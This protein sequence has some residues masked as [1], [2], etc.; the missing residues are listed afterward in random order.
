MTTYTKKFK[1]FIEEYNPNDGDYVVGYRKLDDSEVKIPLIALDNSITSNKYIRKDIDDYANGLISLN[2]GAR[3]GDNIMST[4]YLQGLDGWFGTRR[5]DFEMNSL[6]LREFL[7]VPELRKNKITVMGNQ[8]WFTDSALVKEAVG[9]GMNQYKILFKLEDEEYASF[10][11]NDILKGIYHYENGFYTVYLQ[12]TEL[13]T[14]GITGGEIGVIVTSLNGKAPR[15]SMLLA[16]M[17]NTTD[18]DRQ[19]SI[20]A[21]GLKKYIRVLSGF[22]PA[23]PT[24]EGSYETL[25]VQLG[26]LSGIKNH[27]VFGSLEGYGLYADN[28]YLTGKLIV[29]ND[30]NQPGQELGVYRGQWSSTANYYK[31]DQVTYNGSLFT[32]KQ[33]NNIGHI[34]TGQVDDLWWELTVSKGDDGTSADSSYVFELSN[35]NHT[36]PTDWEGKNPSYGGATSTAYVFEGGKDITDVYTITATVQLPA[37]PETLQIVQNDNTV[38]ITY[39]AD[40]LDAAAILFT[41]TAKGYPTL[42]KTWSISKVKAGQEGDPAVAYWLVTDSPVIKKVITKVSG[43]DVVSYEPSPFV[44]RAFTQV[45]SGPVQQYTGFIRLTYGTQ[46]K[47]VSGA[48]YQF[49]PEA[50]VKSYTIELFQNTELTVLLDKEIVSVVSDGVDGTSPNWNLYIYY[51]GK[52]L[53]ATPTFKV[54]PKDYPV[55]GWYGYPTSDGIWWM[56]TAIVNGV[57]NVIAK[58]SIPIKVTG[59]DGNNGVDGTDGINGK[60]G[61]SLKYK[62]EFNSHPANP[63][64]GWYYYNTVDGKSYVYQDGAWYQMTVDGINGSNGTNGVS[65]FKSTVFLRSNTTP[66]TPTG[67]SYAV[68]VP[69]GWSDGAPNGTTILWT[70]SRI[71]SSTGDIPQTPTWSVPAQMTNTAS[72]EA[73][74]S[75]ITSNPGTPTTNPGNWSNTATTTSIWMATRTAANGVWSAWSV[76]KVKGE[77]GADGINGISIVW[78]GDLATPPANPEI[79]WVYR[80]T[81]N[82]RVYIWNGMAWELMVLDGSDGIDGT[83]G[84]TYYTWLQYSDN[85]NGVPMYQQ[86]TATTQY[87]GIA[88]NQLV[89]TEG[90]D[91]T[92]YTW[93]KFRGDQGVPGGVGADGKTFYTW[94]K[95]AD[96]ASGAGITDNPAGKLYI[97]FAYNKPTATES[98]TPSD[99]AWSLIKGDK[100]DQ[101]IIGP[102]GLSVYITYHD[103][104]VYDKPAKPTGNGTSN[105]WHTLPSSVCIW[106]SQKVASSATTG[107]WGEPIQLRG[108]NGQYID[109]KYA[110]N[111]STTTPPAIVNTD[112]YPAGWFD[113]P[114][115][116][117][118]GDYLWMT[119]ALI[120]ANNTLDGVWA[121]PVR[122]NG[123]QGP[124]GPRGPQGLHGADGLQGPSIVFGGLWLNNKQ[125][126][127]YADTSTAVKYNGKYYYTKTVS[128]ELSPLKIPIGDANNPSTA[129]G[130]VYWNEFVGQFDNIATGLLLADKIGTSELTTNK[131]FIV[132]RQESTGNIIAADGS[133]ITKEEE[134][135]LSANQIIGRLTQGWFMDQGVIRSIAV[136]ADNSTPKL[137]LAADGT[138][139]ATGV[140]ITGTVHFENG[141][142]GSMQVFNTSNWASTVNGPFPASTGVYY[143]RKTNGVT[144]T[145][146]G[147]I[148]GK[149]YFLTG[150]SSQGP[151]VFVGDIYVPGYTVPGTNDPS[152]SA[153]MKLFNS[154]FEKVLVGSQYHIKAKL[155]LFSVGEITAYGNESGSIPS[156]WESL[157]VDKVTIDLING[158]LTVIGGVGGIKAI[159]LPSLSADSALS[160]ATLNSAGDTITFTAKSFVLPTDAR[161]TNARP[162]SD[163]Y[164][165][166]KSATKPS[167]SFSEITGR[168]YTLGTADRRSDTPNTFA[169]ATFTP[170]FLSSPKLGVTNGDFMD[171]IYLN[172]Y[173]DSSGGRANILAINKNNGRMYKM[174]VEQGATSW[175]GTLSEIID[176]NNGQ[177]IGASKTFNA[178]TY[179]NANTYQRNGGY[180]GN[181]D[182]ATLHSDG[183]ITSVGF[184]KSGGTPSQLLRADGGVSTFNWSAKSGQPNQ[185]W[186]GDTMFDYYLWNPI[187]F[188][189][190]SARNMRITDRRDI[191]P[192]PNDIARHMVSSFFSNN[193]MP[194]TDW[195]AGISVAGWQVNYES[196]E[197]AGP[198]AASNTQRSLCYR[199]GR[200]STWG[201]WKTIL[202]SSNWTSTVDGRY[203][204]LTGGTLTGSVTSTS[205]INAASLS[206]TGYIVSTSGWL[207]NNTAGL[208]LYNSA[209]DARFRA[210]NGRWESDKQFYVNGDV[211]WNAGNDGAGSRLDAGLFEGR[212][213]YDLFDS[214]LEP[215]KHWGSAQ[216]IEIGGD[217]NTYYPVVFTLNS[218]KGWTSRISI[219]KNLGSKTANYPGNHSNG[220][221]AMWIRYEGRYCGWDGNG[222]IFNTDGDIYQGYANL[223]ANARVAGSSHG[224]FIIWLRGGGTSYEI[225]TDYKP[226]I[227][228][229]YTRTD[230]G[231][232]PL[233]SDFVEPT[234][235]VTSNGR[236]DIRYTYNSYGFQGGSFVGTSFTGTHFSGTTFKASAGLKSKNICIE[237]DNVGNTALTDNSINNWNGHLNLQYHSGNNLIVN[238]GGGNSMFR[239]GVIVDSSRG[240][241]SPTYEPSISLAIG[242][243][244]TGF[245]WVSDNKIAIRANAVDIAYW[246][247]TEFYV[248]KELYGKNVRAHDGQLFST[249]NGQTVSIGSRNSSFCHYET[250][251]P[252]HHFNKTVRLNGNLMPY[253]GVKYIGSNGEPF[254]T[255]YVDSWFRA[256]SNTGVYFQD[257][258]G[259]WHMTDTDY[260]RSYNSKKIHTGNT[261]YDAFNSGG[262]YYSAR[263][264]SLDNSW[265]N[266]LTPSNA[267]YNVASATT[268]KNIIRPIVAWADQISGVGYLTR[269]SIASC[270]STA[271]WGWMQLSVGNNDAGTSGHLL[272]LGG[273][274]EMTWSGSVNIGINLGVSGILRA[275]GRITTGYDAGRFGGVSCN[276]WFTSAGASG[277]INDTYGGG[278]YQKSS[279]AVSVYGYKVLYNDGSRTWGIS[280][281]NCG[282]KLHNSAH[283]GLNL[284]NDAYTWGIYS[285]SDGN[286]YIGRRSG[287]V[288]D[289]SGSCYLTIGSSTMQYNGNFVATGEVTAY[290][291]IRFKSNI[292]DLTIRGRLQPK[293]FI[294]DNKQ[295]I[296]FIA[297]EVQE[298]Y[299]ELVL[300]GND[301]NRYLSLNY[302]AITAVLSVQLNT[303]EDEV[304]ILKEKVKQLEDKLKQYEINF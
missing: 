261:T 300:T 264:T 136:L 274:G 273:S 265:I 15:A 61:V 281:H 238:Q 131:L 284:A 88:V 219:V 26:D 44:I 169:V 76:S 213:R 241:T 127:G 269:Y 48:V 184:K 303:V 256:K 64:N 237:T 55:D 223:I 85:A 166:A 52:D 84:I 35:D 257:W 260:I 101:G 156:I 235:T 278:I 286:M 29:K 112:R 282:L 14:S 120:K 226:S 11:L 296:G 277:W 109:F 218:D 233:Y 160:G 66:P 81:D 195:W 75:T 179:F 20:F 134:K 13:V 143:L 63:E 97:G 90:T 230:I 214:N 106:M 280:G 159:I 259:G 137:R 263:G 204:P 182:Q 202:D 54:P 111:T 275:D 200:A 100:G 104:S 70:S 41:A 18:E 285:N 57:S 119:S 135:N 164:A 102:D 28:V 144:I 10:E 217:L 279:D 231:S 77:N 1:E 209:Q 73:K 246:N 186:G 304:S 56:S 168:L 43:Q 2:N 23:D 161:L 155:P 47:V 201:S 107:T 242:D 271:G 289:S 270:R 178:Y 290:S 33:I 34:P 149:D 291:D 87:I 211:V 157:P 5:G 240:S 139:T 79:N 12:V 98:N 248:H 220:T 189:V 165:W 197:L 232:A 86:P 74:Y 125:Y 236:L 185:L 190:S 58:W 188:N 229:Y 297:Q 94:I 19:G 192:E 254:G 142:I 294:K 37:T 7:E 128:P 183:T 171:A 16:R 122:V 253:N 115:V 206:S 27:P 194:S 199:S 117:V 133:I 60:D 153:F 62:G 216:T 175:N 239:H 228:V 105:G 212:R 224:G 193:Y 251:A 267:V 69:A 129:A 8:F 174:N 288:N 215:M 243:S 30:P 293:T 95:Y 4:I 93:S 25:R 299:P 227:N 49:I 53:P 46:V 22:N 50:D 82:G 110:K 250:T 222:N 205:T 80:D 152:L 180:W 17:N 249:F 21:D 59:E 162:A 276:N 191:V 123:E 51:K 146:Q 72:F 65:S 121:P 148:I 39:I 268:G 89:Q 301:D 45:G 83:N 150:D 6:T 302:G 252:E 198:A 71:F 187:N 221:S 42:N 96:N 108:E 181:A 244:D 163:V 36:I 247:P 68:P 258:G 173:L 32:S 9:M 262:G 176:S 126:Y 292:Q 31:Y 207:Q 203:L 118:S 78:K 210:Q 234:T 167:Y 298:L 295:S 116:I 272:K 141:T 113:K 103:N 177:T 99:Y 24:A 225:Y 172:T 114:P 91:P 40:S 151:S 196:W 3:I 140:T 170:F 147:H 92:K 245:N 158:K 283:I 154:L 132:N 67:G 255:I 38:A 266:C 145:P 287:N 208:G 138:I 124:A 130:K